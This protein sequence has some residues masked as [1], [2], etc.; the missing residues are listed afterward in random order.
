MALNPVIVAAIIRAVLPNSSI[1]MTLTSE[2]LEKV[3]DFVIETVKLV[4]EQFGDK[5]GKFKH[6]QALQ[7]MGEKMPHKDGFN[8]DQL[9]HG[10]VQYVKSVK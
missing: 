10:F 2:I 8:M 7:R 9:I 5:P 3:S 4:Q 6:A 1:A